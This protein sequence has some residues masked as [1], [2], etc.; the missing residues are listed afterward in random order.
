[1]IPS[2]PF[3]KA[4]ALAVS[5]MLILGGMFLAHPETRTELA[6]GGEP[7][8]ARMGNAFEDM[9]AGT[10]TAQD[11]VA[12]TP[13]PTTAEAIQPVRQQQ[14]P[15]VNP[16][17]AEPPAAPDAVLPEAAAPVA[18]PTSTPSVAPRPLAAQ[19]SVS[20]AT[21]T[22]PK[23]TIAAASPDTAAPTGSRRPQRRDPEKAAQIAAARPEPTA[24]RGN[25]QRDSRRG[26]ST[27]ETRQADAGSQG[28]TRK[29]APQSGNAAASNYPGQVMRKISRVRKPNVRAR[30]TATIAFRIAAN[31]G[32]ATISVARSS[33]SSALD[34]AALRVVRTAAP[35]PPPPS[36]ATR[37]FS[38]QIQGR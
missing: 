21:P 11:A 31:G 28:N 15:K 8:R 4:V 32:L 19:Q 20:V 27:A 10:L 34:R 18:P 2:S 17:P 26:D 12:V 37:S 23:E 22:P 1:M 13:P 3:G 9:A 33:G 36:G 5:A 29:A 16:A 14:T 30:G 35:F 38:I 6:G 7:V 25:A 24:P